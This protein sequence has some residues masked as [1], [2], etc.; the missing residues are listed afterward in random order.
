MDEKKY[1]PKKELTAFCIAGMGQG[2]IYAL[3]S[4]YISD[5]YLNV[6]QLTPM[7]VL[8]LMLLA[9]VW[10]AINDPMMGMIID[11]S[12]LKSGKMKPFIKFALIPIAI[13]TFLM[14]LSPNLDKTELMIF[15]AFVYVGW[16]MIYTVGDV[17]FWGIPNVITPSSN[18]RSSVISISKIFNSIGSAV[19]EVLFLV[20]GLIIAQW[21]KNSPEA[22][23]PLTVQKRKYLLMAIVTV[24]LGTVLICSLSRLRKELRC[25]FVSA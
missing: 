20:I 16:G 17:A 7:F 13:M 14:Y 12:N 10:D 24:T 23:D 3:M 19:P 11:R 8:L 5:Y 18:E 4:S 21:V 15:S 22:I 25:L 6:L 2:M 1:V 9:R